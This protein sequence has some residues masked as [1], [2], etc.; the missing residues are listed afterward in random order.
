M[1]QKKVRKKIFI[2]F[3]NTD[4]KDSLN[5]DITQLLTFS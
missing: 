4:D 5:S 3:M 2:I 1:R